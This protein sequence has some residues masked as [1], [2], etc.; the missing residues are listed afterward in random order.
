M[1]P[2]ACWSLLCLLLDQAAAST[3]LKSRQGADISSVK[4]QFNGGC[5][6]DRRADISKALD[7]AITLLNDLP[8]EI[9]WT[10]PA[11]VEFFG[12]PDNNCTQVE[13]GHT[14]LYLETGVH[15]LTAVQTS[16]NPRSKQ[17]SVTRKRLRE[18]GGMNQ[19]K[20]RST[21]TVTKIENKN[22]GIRIAKR[23]R[24]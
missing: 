18:D 15:L 6:S 7:D 19:G 22:W 13:T 5:P 14:E 24:M 12:D 2:T 11:A 1:R 23:I 21:S 9:Y 8:S 4:L 10:E 17:F 20:S 16:T 3:L